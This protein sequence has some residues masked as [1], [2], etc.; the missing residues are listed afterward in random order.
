LI[1]ELNATLE[2]KLHDVIWIDTL[3]LDDEFGNLK[4]EYTNDGLHLSEQGYTILEQIVGR[5]MKKNEK[6]C[7]YSGKSWI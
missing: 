2:R 5:A 6:N 4:R 3:E 7:Y 1:D